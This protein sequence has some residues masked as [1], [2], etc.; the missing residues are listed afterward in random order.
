MAGRQQRTR[1][2]E[3]RPTWR[4]RLPYLLAAVVGAAAL[5]G[6][7]DTHAGI[8]DTAL[9][10]GSGG[11]YVSVGNPAKL[12][13]ATFT[14]ETW[15]KRTGTGVS[16]S[17]GT[18]GVAALLPL[19]THGAP[20]AENS[21]V[22]ANWILGIS[23]S[24]TG[25]TN[26]LAADFEEGAG[27]A[28]PGLNH[29][30]YGTTVIANDTW[31]HAAA[32][33]DGTTWKLYLNGNLETTLTVGQPPRS[34]SIQQVGLGAMITSTGSALGRF[35]GTLDEARVW[36]HALTGAE[37]LAAK[38][39]ELTSGTGLVARWGMN[40]GTGTT[41]GDSIA[42]AANGTITGSGY[43]WES[44]GNAAPVAT[45]DSYSTPQGTAKVVAAPGVLGNDTDANS[46]PLTAVLD[47]DVSHGTLNLASDGGF[48]YTPTGG[49]SGPD[50]FTYHAFDGTDPSNTVTVDLTVTG[51]NAGLDLGS[52]GA[53]VA[54]GNPA[55]LGLATFTVETWFKRTGT[56]VSNS[57]GTG[58][59]AALLPLVTHGAPEAENSN[60][61][62]NW[63]LGIS[64]SG[65]GTTNVLAADFEE[66]AG[67][68]SPGLN[69]P[70]YGTTV[71]TNGVWHHAAATYDGTTWKLYLDGN[72]ET[73]LAVGQP[74]RSDSIQQVGLG[75]MINSSGT[76]LGRFQGVL[77]ESRVWDHA[78]TGAQILAAKD[79][80]LTS[81]TGLVARWG[82][83][84]GT[85]TTVGDSIATAANGTVTGSGSAWTT[86]FT[87]AAGSGAP[88]A[89]TLNAPADGATGTSAS[90]TLS[91]GVSD[92]D[93][94]PLTVTFYGRPY[95]SGNFT[96]IAQNTSVA[97]GSTTTTG[98]SGLGD[99][100]EYE[101]YATVG[102]GTHTTTGPTWTFHTADG[103][104]PVFVGAGDI[105][106]CARTQDEATGAVIGGI[107]G[108]V[109]TAG[110]NVYP[111]GTATQFANCYDPGWGGAIKA[112]T[113]PIPGNHDWNTGN[114]DGYNSYFGSAA[115][116]GGGMSYYSYD[117]PSS[118]W[119]VVN[120]DSECQYVTGGCAAGSAQELWLRADLSANASKNVIA[121]WHKPRFSSAVTNLTGMQAFYDDLYEFG[122][123]IMLQGH[124]HVYERMA[125]IDASGAVDTAYGVRQFTVGTGGAA[126]Q[127]FGTILASSL[128]RNSS[129]YG[130]LKFTLHSSS[131]DWQ[132][133]PIAGQTFTDSGTGL[134]HGAAPGANTAPVATG[135]SYTTAQDT[136]KVVA[137]PGV[138]G[139]DTDANSDPLTAVLDTDVSHGTLNL[140]SD[141]GFTYT[142]TGGY[143]GPDSFTYHAF[144]GTDPSNTVTVSLTV[145]PASATTYYVDNTDGA[146][147]DSGPGTIAAPFCTIGKAAGL[148]A[149]GET[150]H[151]LAGTYAETVNGPNSGT[152]GN[153][154]TY[155]AGS[156]VIVTG[157]GTATGNA[158]R[159]SSKSYIVIDNFTI[160]DTV[161]YGIY[162][163][164]SDHI[165]ISN[166]HVSSAGSPV[167]G[168]TRAGIYFSN[169][170][171]STITGTTSDH[172]S[173]DGIR[174]TGG[175]SGNVLSD[176]VSYAN[177]EEWQRN[178]AGIQVT[179]AGS[180]GNILRHNITYGNE[181]TGLQFYAGAQ[182]NVIVGN[183]T[184]GNGDHGIDNNAAP[185]NTIVGN[186]VQGNVTAGINLEGA[187][188]P[189]SGNATVANNI[190]RRQRP[191]PP[192]RRRHRQ[193]PAHEHPRRRPV[194]RPAR[195]S[196]TTSSTCRAAAA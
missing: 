189:G 167:S 122:V 140:A 138:L 43:A 101:W 61:D 83:N 185:G 195:R 97:S 171:N 113:R 54:V 65:T 16:N 66:G 96:Q 121:L 123:D 77:D 147:S 89:P 102:D 94:D 160:K 168:S 143:S 105:A 159:M 51:A 191:A 180:D 91:V 69:H 57:T 79:Q 74:P 98:W 56:G 145:T 148:V 24:G 46:D 130:V 60:V 151:V 186:T 119:H 76:P 117:I 71:I 142:P 149:A 170:D 154:I 23:T 7:Q 26:V 3:E 18:G 173:Q 131:Y 116:D 124:D 139:N 166:D 42:T 80:E 137:A 35:Q 103:A 164:G 5:F 165:T 34:D 39:Q 178:A 169:T 182:N 135:E 196:T 21:N 48:T 92:P 36:D 133:F 70:V 78:L 82:M 134:T 161:D 107:D 6:L 127:S 86:G 45:A 40:E 19:V 12:G 68:A 111:D 99:G 176:N 104:D 114:L 29:P 47:T 9:N 44:T 129:T 155:M 163:S 67:G 1:G 128:V 72:L 37:I 55:K 190:I 162:S 174:L 25:T 100:Q 153:P 14:V 15:F 106:D 73:T 126:L 136:A 120:L 115:T 50:S 33:Y 17:T 184:Y 150:V 156:G 30:V 58:G 28:S 38:D 20:Q 10:L 158:F 181:D 172:N 90:P 32:T 64:T 110:D 112:R 132:F 118:N 4:R 22:D 59:V 144:D 193:R 109:W 183:L 175:S 93:A 84:E 141:G 179:G 13:L 53:Y 125:P 27:G 88:D 192:G 194:D 75:A 85:G 152:A 188:A 87:P 146:C 157:N 2:R 52:G 177:A 8:G 49:Y 81:G 108:H 95:A 62:A 11:A 187:S 63:I 31:Y 41:V